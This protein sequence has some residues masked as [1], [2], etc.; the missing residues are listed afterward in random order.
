MCVHMSVYMYNG[1]RKYCL[2]YNLLPYRL[3]LKCIYLKLIHI[4]WRYTQYREKT[5]YSEDTFKNNAMHGVH[6]YGKQKKTKLSIESG[7]WWDHPLPLERHKFSRPYFYG[8]KL[9]HNITVSGRGAPDPSPKLKYML[10]C[11]NRQRH[12]QPLQTAADNCYVIITTQ[13]TTQSHFV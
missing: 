1:F 3:N 5:L 11:T 2:F 12:T 10:V 4:Y 9:Q 13:L 6:L 7:I 8:F